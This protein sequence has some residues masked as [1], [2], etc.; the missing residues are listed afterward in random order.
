MRH[1]KRYFTRT[2]STFFAI[3]GLIAAIVAGCDQLERPPRIVYWTATFGPTNTPESVA[4]ESTA[5]TTADAAAAEATAAEVTQ[6]VTLPATAI[7]ALPTT[8][9]TTTP[10]STSSSLPTTAAPSGTALPAGSPTATATFMGAIISGEY[11]P[12]PPDTPIPSNTPNPTDAAATA[13][14]PTVPPTTGATPS[15]GAVPALPTLNGEMVGVQLDVNLSD[16]DWDYA[17]SRIEELGVRWVKVQIPWRDMQPFCTEDSSVAFFNRVQQHLE[18]ANRR[19]FNVLVSIVKAP[20]CFRSVQAEDG[21]PDDPQ[22]LARFITFLYAQIRA[23]DRAQDVAYFGN[24]I[25]AVEIWNEP[26][27]QREW[28]GTLPFNGAGYMRL[29]APAY[30]AVRAISPDIPVIT[31]GLAP[32]SSLGFSVDDREFLRQMYAAG[33]G[34][35]QDPNLYV[36]IHPYG[37]GNP[38]D[39]T[40][41]DAVEGRGFDDDPHFFFGDTLNEY[42][43][44]MNNN[45]HQNT[46]LWTTEFGY[47]TWDSLPAPAPDEWMTYNDSWAQGGYTIRALQIEQERGDMGPTILWNLNF[48]VL[49]G[50]I[51]NRD[52]RV[53]YSMLVPGAGCAID[54]TSTSRTERPVFWM[55]FD[56]LR[57]DVDL[58]DYCGIPPVPIPGLG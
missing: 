27:L 14:A 37:W 36:G 30:Q 13:A 54:P 10:T 33:L 1:T 40:C 11:T 58:D 28:Q 42:R 50:L 55:L 34:G 3:L 43:N 4:L 16:E 45:G 6:A 24:Y 2:T 23:G 31:A 25:D 53:A 9:P 17:M 52:E 20:A 49:T 51:E 48:A 8:S 56:A 22:T 12:P 44:I 29:F 15:P 35:Y 57:G 39:S 46:R 38:P 41:C 19:G 5:L 18:D 21:P 7:A 26:N 47:A 32:T